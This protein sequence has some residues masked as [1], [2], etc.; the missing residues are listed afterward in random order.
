MP[1]LKTRKAVSERFKIKRKKKKNALGQ[2][3]VTIEKRTDGQDHFNGRESGKITRNK[4]SDNNVSNSM[5]K[6]IR[7]AMPHA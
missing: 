7:R 4:R 6:Q 5:H 2:T 1:K 3:V